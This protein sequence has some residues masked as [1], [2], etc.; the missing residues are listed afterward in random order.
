[1]PPQAVLTA[2]VTSPLTVQFDLSGSTGD[3]V[4]YTLTFGD[5]SAA[6]TGSDITVAVVHTYED[7]G[8]YIATLT[9]QDA[10]G[11]MDTDSVP[12]TVTAAPAVTAELG[13]A[14]TVGPAPL[15]VNFLVKG[16]APTGKK[17]VRWHLDFDDGDPFEQFVNL[18]TLDTTTTHSYTATGTYTAVLTVEDEDGGTATD[19]VTITVTSPL[20]EIMT[21]SANPQTPFVGAPV[22]FTFTAKAGD[23]ARKLVK[24]E[25]RPGDDSNR[26]TG[27]SSSS[28]SPLNVTHVYAGYT[29]TGS[30]TATVKVWDD[31]DNTDE[32]T[33]D[34]DVVVTP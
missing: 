10:R 20:P 23:A 7:P 18:T 33:L 9:V 14:N 22:T 12:I 6:A 24:W 11:R 5:G 32:L 16:Q 13:A 30:Y 8:D 19:S 27:M 2:S 34:V 29:Q 17:I 28:V 26:V 25:L 21:F 1:A 31:L 15:V 3:I 4:S